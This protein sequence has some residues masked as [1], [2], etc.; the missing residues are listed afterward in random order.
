MEM[1]A[2][3]RKAQRGRRC[4]RDLIRAIARRI[5]SEA[6]IFYFDLIQNTKIH[7]VS[8]PQFGK[9]FEYQEA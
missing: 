1:T 4:K 2:R 3:C 8:E 6:L 7:Y 5:R 9:K